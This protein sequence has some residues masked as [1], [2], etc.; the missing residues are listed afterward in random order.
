MMNGPERV[1]VRKLI[2]D[3]D[4]ARLLQATLAPLLIR[5]HLK[6]L[7]ERMAHA[8][9]TIADDLARQMDGAAPATMA[10][11]ASR[12]AR[13]RVRIDRWIAITNLDIELGCLKCI[14]RRERR[15]TRRLRH[16]LENVRSL[17][18]NLHREL[19]QLERLLLRIESLLREMERPPVAA[20]MP[21]HR[22][23]TI[24][25]PGHGRYRP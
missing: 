16:A 12:L 18:H 5:P 25:L 17:Q 15:V 10:R 19:G 22:A 24:T 7:I 4:D 9:A 23:D 2:G 21:R 20:A 1:V 8:H 3:L 14:A 11:G 6:F 13:M